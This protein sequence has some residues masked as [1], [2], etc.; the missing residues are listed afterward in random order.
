MIEIG[1]GDVLKRG[2]ERDGRGRRACGSGEEG[3]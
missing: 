2:G 1:T 3:L